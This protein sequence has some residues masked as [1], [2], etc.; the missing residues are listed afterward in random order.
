MVLSALVS[1]AALAVTALPDSDDSLHFHLH[2]RAT[3]KD[4]SNPIYKNAKAKIE[5][6]VADLLP[7][8]TVQ[9]KVAQL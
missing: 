3:N 8:M 5:D 9:E 1:L 2:A 7:R 6:R 4:G